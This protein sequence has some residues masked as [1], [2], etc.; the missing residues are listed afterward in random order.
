MPKDAS[1][2]FGVWTR[3]SEYVAQLFDYSGVIC[4]I[5]YTIDA[6]ESVHLFCH[7]K[8][9][10]ALLNE[11]ALLKLLYLRITEFPIRWNGFCVQN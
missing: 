11:N 10:E 8:T 2:E 5:M 9:K 4:K 3:N 1:K 6:V 7:K